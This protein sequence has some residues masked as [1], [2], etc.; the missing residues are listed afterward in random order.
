VSGQVVVITGASSGI[1]AA[2]AV[3][4]GRRGELLALGARRERELRKVALQSGTHALAVVTDVTRREDVVH[5]RD[6]ALEAYGQVDVWVNNAGQGINRFVSE[7][8]DE[9]VRRTIDSVLMSTLYGM[10]AILPHFKERGKGS[11]I[12]V[13]SFLGRVPITTYR[14]IYSASKSAV[15]V[16]SAN[17]RM[18]LHQKYPQIHVSVVMPGIVD[19][20]FHD[21]ATPPLPARAGEMLWGSKVESADDVAARIVSLMDNPVPELYTNPEG[22]RMVE[23]YFRDVGAFEDNLAKRQTRQT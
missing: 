13:S 23:G 2:L 22:P 9:D 8:S 5:L 7:L 11:I 14:S 15:N 4:L 10:Q 3:Q 18:E 21:I 12:N 16:L 20:P 17:L 19:T 1:G 6:A